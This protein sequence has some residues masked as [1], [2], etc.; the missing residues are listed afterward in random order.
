[1]VNIET[2]YTL[3]LSTRKP[4]WKG[5]LTVLEDKKDKNSQQVVA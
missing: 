4:Y 2:F 1:M 3:K 5:K